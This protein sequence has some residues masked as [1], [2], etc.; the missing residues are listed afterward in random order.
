MLSLL[1]LY[2]SIIVTLTITLSNVNANVYYEQQWFNISEE[3]RI[4]IFQESFN[5]RNKYQ[6]VSAFH[7]IHDL[8]FA[9]F[10]P[11]HKNC[12]GV[13]FCDGS[14]QQYHNATFRHRVQQLALKGETLKNYITYN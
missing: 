6:C 4:M 11:L 3:S 14:L 9:L 8:V 13:P 12:V 7:S 1:I 10:D 2:S 5:V